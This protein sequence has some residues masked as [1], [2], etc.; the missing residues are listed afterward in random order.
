MVDIRAADLDSIAI[1]HHH[2]DH[3]KG[4]ARSR[5]L[6]GASLHANLTTATRLGLDPVNDCRTFTDL[7]RVEL[8]PDLTVLPIPVPHDDADNVSFIVSNGGGV[9]AA[10]VTDLGVPTA[11]LMGHLRG[12]SHISIESNYDE[13]RLLS[14]PYPESLKRRIMG[15]GGHLSN[16]QT[17]GI[18][19]EIVGSDLRSIVLCHLSER[20][21]APHIAESEVLIRIEDRFGGDLRISRQDGPEFSHWLGQAE[22]EILTR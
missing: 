22:A 20:N 16:S 19:D 2:A 21:N 7:E 6:W 1:T 11:E 13:G 17:A 3:G 8:G 15:N 18:L 9:R 14:G 5:K 10:I 4:A 12:C